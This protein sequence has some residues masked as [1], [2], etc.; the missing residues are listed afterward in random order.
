MVNQQ[1]IARWMDKPTHI[2][3]MA[4]DRHSG[5]MIGG[6]EPVGGYRGSL[7]VRSLWG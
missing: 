3:R 2:T 6:W 5:G 4:E 7:P 1:E